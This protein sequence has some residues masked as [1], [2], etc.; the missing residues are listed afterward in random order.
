[1]Q[2]A[3]KDWVAFGLVDVVGYFVIADAAGFVDCWTSD[4]GGAGVFRR[5]LDV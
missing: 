5:D 1:M 2:F 4:V 3:E